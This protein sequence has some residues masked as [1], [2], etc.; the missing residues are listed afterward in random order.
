MYL[1]EVYNKAE[2][3]PDAGNKGIPMP[4]PTWQ[5]AIADTRRSRQIIDAVAGLSARG[6]YEEAVC[7][8]ADGVVVHVWRIPKWRP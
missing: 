2:L 4:R 1:V 8:A 7:G 6:A 5:G 3:K